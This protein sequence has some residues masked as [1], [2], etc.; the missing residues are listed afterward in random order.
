MPWRL[1]NLNTKFALHTGLDGAI[2]CRH[3]QK[4]ETMKQRTP[5]AVGELDR[6]D[7]ML[8]SAMGYSCPKGKSAAFNAG[9][10]RCTSN[11]RD[12]ETAALAAQ[13]TRYAQG[14]GART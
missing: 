2:V 13:N 7:G 3:T 14:S 8:H 6:L 5:Q 11:K 4:G 1:L 10:D 9:Y 12:Y